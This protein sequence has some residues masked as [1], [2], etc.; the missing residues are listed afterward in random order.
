MSHSGLKNIH[1][2]NYFAQRDNKNDFGIATLTS[3]PIL[4]EGT[5]VLKNSRRA[6]TLCPAIFVQTDTIRVYNV[7]LQSIHLGNDGYQ[8]LSEILDPEDLKD[9]QETK[10]VAGRMK[11]AF[12]KRVLRVN[13]Q[14]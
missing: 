4:N 6:L 12:L 10:L 2:K 7:H 14:R 1:L 5:I 13:R 11:S 9:V 8:A 3:Y